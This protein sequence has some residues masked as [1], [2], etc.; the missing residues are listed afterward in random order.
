MNNQ[1]S[2]EEVNSFGDWLRQR[3]KTLDWTQAALAQRTG[4]TAATIRKIEANERKPSWQLA[5]L[6]ATALGVPVDGRTAF[7]QAARQL[8]PVTQLP[9]ANQEPVATAPFPLS[10]P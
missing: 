9:P 7:V 1:T 8:R 4:C 6:L 10:S 3:R 5:E 2:L